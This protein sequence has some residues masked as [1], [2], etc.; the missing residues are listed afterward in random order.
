MSMAQVLVLPIE[1]MLRNPF[2][3]KF[4][5]MRY[6]NCASVWLGFGCF[7][8]LLLIFLFLLVFLF[9]WM[10][11]YPKKQMYQT[12]NPLLS[13]VKHTLVQLSQR[14]QRK[15]GMKE[16]ATSLPLKESL[17]TTATAA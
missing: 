9:L 5:E 14:K 10:K 17:R 11:L 12:N 2:G 8:L 3:N 16:T 1:E 15:Y 7:F 13:T 4:Y 6:K